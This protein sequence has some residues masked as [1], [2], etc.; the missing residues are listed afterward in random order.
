MKK[1]LNIAY[2]NGAEGMIRRGGTSSGDSGG[3]STPTTVGENDV[4]FYDY[5]GTV[6]YSY[7]KDEFLKLT[8]MP[9]L[10][11]REGLVCQEWNWDL[12]DAKDYVGKYGMQ[13][14]GATYITDNGET[15]IYIQLYKAVDIPLCIQQSISNGVI[16]NW[17]DGSPTNTIE[18]VGNVSLTHNYNS[19][20]NYVI[21]L[22]PIDNCQLDFGHKEYMFGENRDEQSFINKIEIG[23]NVSQLGDYCFA[24]ANLQ[25]GI[26]IPKGIITLG[27]YVFSCS[28][29]PHI[30]YPNGVKTFGNYVGESNYNLLELSIPNGVENSGT[31]YYSAQLRKFIIPESVISIDDYCLYECY[32]IRYIIIPNGVTE[33]ANDM[34]YD[35]NSLQFVVFPKTIINIPNTTFE[36]C[37]DIKYYDFS[38]HTSIPTLEKATA[39]EAAKWTKI[40]V[41]DNLYDQW[42]IAT[43]WTGRASCI[44]KKSDWDALNA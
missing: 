2:L 37:Y 16:I 4:T 14:I 44:I 29:V 35:C 39:L 12:A 23:K 19:K 9:P 17:G 25:K 11:T 24:Y 36:R 1:N 34:C 26:T 6:L 30:T 27:S 28:S 5:D 3:G 22:M 13:N 31:Y 8:E 43:N 32:S 20:G 18:G 38:N 40:I 42:I 15:R 21:R 41:P 7:T 10:P 33:P